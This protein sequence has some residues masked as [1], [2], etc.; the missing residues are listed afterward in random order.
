[1]SAVNIVHFSDLLCVWAYGGEANLYRLVEKFGDKIS[2]DVHYCSVF[3]DTHTK[4]NAMWGK[5]G[6][7]GGYADHVSDVAGQFDGLALHSDVWSRVQPR[8]SA[9]P[10]LL[11][12]AVELIELSETASEQ[13]KFANR[14]SVKTAHAL[15]NSF[16]AEARDIST[17]TEQRL[18]CDKVGVDFDA[19]LEKIETGEAIANLTADYEMALKLGVQGSPT[20]LMNEGRQK[21]YGNVSLGVLTANI[22]ELISNEQDEAASACS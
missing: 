2:V 13:P 15:R 19:V 16:F 10:H 7:F 18:V 21:L 1:M 17:W 11:L 20:Y 12:K 3:P 8:S 22:S 6:G 14:L 4:I 5:R 9:S